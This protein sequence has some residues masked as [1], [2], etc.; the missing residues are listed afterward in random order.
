M[1]KTILVHVDPDDAGSA[2]RIQ[3]ATQIAIDCKATLIG[4]AAALSPVAVAILATGGAA[5]ALGALAADPNELEE[6]FAIAK[7]EFVRWTE[8]TPVKTEW[9]T[10]VGFPSEMLAAMTARA[11]LIVVGPARRSSADNGYFDYGEL[12]MRVG[13]PVLLVPEGVTKLDLGTAVVA[14]RNTRESRRALT[15][16]LPFLATAG[17]IDLVHVRERSDTGDEAASLAD[18]AS[19]LEGHCICA[20]TKTIG[21]ETHSAARSLVDFALRTGAGLVVAGAYGHTRV[22]EWIFGGVTRELLDGC[23]VPCLLSR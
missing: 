14:W 9:R 5:V 18:A 22:R 13:R 19:L 7:A 6:K 16:A 23:P 15:D 2:A 11:D 12:I 10:A 17:A 3:V 20:A 4:V 21:P 8:A 1:Y